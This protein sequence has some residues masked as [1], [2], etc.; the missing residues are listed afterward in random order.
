MQ[1]PNPLTGPQMHAVAQNDVP[2][3][4]VDPNAKD[5]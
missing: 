5:A 2:R 1:S 3:G 4:A